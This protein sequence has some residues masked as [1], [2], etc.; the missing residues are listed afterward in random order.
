MSGNGL[1]SSGTR[2]GQVAGFCEHSNKA[3]GPMECGNFLIASG[4]VRFS[5]RP[6]LRGFNIYFNFLAFS[7]QKAAIIV[8]F[9]MSVHLSA[10][11]NLRSAEVEGQSRWILVVII[12]HLEIKQYLMF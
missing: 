1:D 11:N 6:L 5:Q 3:L 2:Q 8:C 4:N 9:T 12:S 7:Q 10:R